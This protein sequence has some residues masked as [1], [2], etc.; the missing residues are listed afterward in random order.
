MGEVE[1]V[2]HYNGD[3]VP[4]VAP[5][6]RPSSMKE[7]SSELLTERGYPGGVRR[8]AIAAR[9]GHA[10]KTGMVEAEA[11]RGTTVPDGRGCETNRPLYMGRKTGQAKA[12]S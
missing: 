12:V 10:D 1:G 4:Q 2:D 9:R 7:G 6:T 8:H 3:R 5:K 11:N